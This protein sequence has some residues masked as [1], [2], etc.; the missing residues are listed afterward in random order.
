MFI[1]IK[2]GEP[3]GYPITHENLMQLI[4]SNVSIPRWPLTKDL[5]DL[6]FAVYEYSQ[7]P[8]VLPSD[9]KVVEEGTPVWAKDD[10]RG[11]FISQT[12]VIRDMTEE[13]KEKSL[14]SGWSNVRWIRDDKLL[15]S[16]WTQ[17]PNSPISEEKRKEWFDYRQE[18]RDVTKQPNP[19]NIIWPIQPE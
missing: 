12:F 7:T 1:Q 16:D 2:N 4:P 6:G 19:F 10:I 5:I 11:D 8:E 3:F 17:I 13:E 9:F 18:L 15:R 14:N